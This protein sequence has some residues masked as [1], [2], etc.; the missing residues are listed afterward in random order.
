MMW[1]IQLPIVATDITHLHTSQDLIQV[2]V[3]WKPLLT[4]PFKLVDP[5]LSA[6]MMHV[7]IYNADSETDQV[8][9]STLK[10]SL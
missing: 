3:T 2:S 4:L 5:V 8:I 7:K 1:K 10:Q 6:S 9:T